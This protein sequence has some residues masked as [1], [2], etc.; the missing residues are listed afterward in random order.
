MSD[1]SK[2]LSRALKGPDTLIQRLHLDAPH[3]FI[4][5]SDQHKGSGDKADGFK[6]CKPAYVAALNHYLA[7]G[8]TLILLG[9]VEELWEQ[10]FKEVL[11]EYEDVLSLEGQF[12]TSRYYRMWGNHDDDWMS[13]RRVRKHLASFM[14]NEAV[15][16]ALRFEVVNDATTVGT[17]LLVHGHQGDA[18]SDKYR[19]LSKIGVRYFWRLLQR[20]TGIGK[21]TPAKD[22]CL[23][24][25]HDNEMY[26]WAAS[27]QSLILIAGHTHRPV[28]SSRTHLQKLEQELVAL[29]AQPT[30]PELEKEIEEK[31]AEIERRKEEHPPCSDQVKPKPVY[32]NT[33]CCVFS[34]GDITGIEIEKRNN[35]FD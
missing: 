29:Q 7:A 33:G 10:G 27:E 14:P 32:F 21:E 20:L 12:P 11:R 18:W 3:R 26:R 5:F 15:Y 16:E 34:D 31:Q 23:R 9:D 30:T 6:D 17:L 4:I 8:Y 13:V 25:D 2:G 19:F 35:P 28:W 1:V 22:A 24:S